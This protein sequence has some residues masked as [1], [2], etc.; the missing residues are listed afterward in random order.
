MLAPVRWAKPMIE[1]VLIDERGCPVKLTAASLSTGLRAM[2]SIP[3]C[4]LALFFVALSALV[5]QNGERL[6]SNY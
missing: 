3:S 2:I 5:G 6:L 1:E 4:I